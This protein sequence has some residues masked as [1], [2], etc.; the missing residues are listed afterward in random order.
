MRTFL[1]DEEAP[2]LPKTSLQEEAAQEDSHRKNQSG[3]QS[4]SPL[5]LQHLNNAQ[6][7]SGSYSPRP[8]ETVNNYKLKPYRCDLC[9]IGFDDGAELE[10]HKEGIPHKAKLVEI[11]KERGNKLL[12]ASSAS[13]NAEEDDDDDDWSRCKLCA[14]NFQSERV[15]NGIMKVNYI[16]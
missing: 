14:T 5:N 8:N 13:N 6:R 16:Y 1:A 2:P 7:P 9:S 12:N 4:K 10:K 11:E 3:D 15:M